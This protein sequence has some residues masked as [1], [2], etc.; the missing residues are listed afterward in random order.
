MSIRMVD[1]KD[2]VF[3]TKI[4]LVVASHNA[5]NTLVRKN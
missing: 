2:I 1:L 3:Y 5:P 4:V